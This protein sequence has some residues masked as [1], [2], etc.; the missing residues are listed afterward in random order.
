MNLVLDFGNTR[1]KAGVFEGDQLLH[2][3]VFDSTKAFLKSEL[4]QL[5]VQRCLIASV[6]EAHS[7]V[8]DQLS[9]LFSTKL[10]STST[11]V[12]VTNLYTSALTLGSDRLA[13]SVGAF[14]LYPHK[15]VLTIDAGTCIKYNFVNSDNEYLGGAISPGLSMR[16]KA[17]HHFTK[18]LPLIEADH[19]YDKLIGQSTAESLL[20]GALV[21][22]ACEVDGMM[23]R[24]K[25]NYDD[26]IVVLTGGDADYLGK[27]LKNRF[28]ANQNLVLVGLNTI[29]NY[30]VEK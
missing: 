25:A 15:N 2:T 18:A 27:Q 24:Y 13:A 7:S 28:F 19:S 21:A 17:M 9:P 16:L 5:P 4:L 23:D 29:L 6:T 20:S 14:S 30:S 22:A 12:P 10:F 3:H 26:L 1:L 8:F 11:P